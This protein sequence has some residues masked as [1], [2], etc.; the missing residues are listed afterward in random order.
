[1]IVVIMQTQKGLKKA[2]RLVGN[3]GCGELSLLL[4]YLEIAIFVQLL[5]NVLCHVK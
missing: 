3:C 2:A 5:K 4:F 1:M